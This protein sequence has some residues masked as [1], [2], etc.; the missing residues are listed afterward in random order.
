[1][2]ITIPGVYTRPEP[3]ELVA[4]QPIV[5]LDAAPPAGKRAIRD[6]G[7]AANWIRAKAR[8]QKLWGQEWL[9]SVFT[10]TVAGVGPAPFGTFRGRIRVPE[11]PLRTTLRVGVRATQVAGDTGTI[12]FVSGNGAGQATIS[13]PGGTVDT[14][15]FSDGGAIPHMP[16]SWVGPTAPGF[17]RYEEVRLFTSS[18]IG[19][20]STTVHAACVQHLPLASVAG[21]DG[22]WRGFFDE[23]MTD[24]R[25]LSSRFGRQMVEVL[26]DF[27]DVARFPRMIHSWMG[28]DGIAAAPSIFHFGPRLRRMITPI[29]SGGDGSLRELEMHCRLGS[30]ARPGA[31]NITTGDLHNQI[32]N[33]DLDAPAGPFTTRFSRVPADGEGWN[34]SPGGG[35]GPPKVDQWPDQNDLP[36][37]PLAFKMGILH[38]RAEFAPILSEVKSFSIWGM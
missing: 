20:T 5:G 15:F 12:E 38:L 11:L 7:Q 6:I 28:I 32:F 8:A 25:V 4:G 18:A 9:D 13:I 17:A 33:P 27:R 34:E 16:V 23:E 22:D 37:V 1:M 21:V 36:G 31:L 3:V 19:A 2:A 30:G 24:D 10:D 14:W 26:N 35:D 29:N